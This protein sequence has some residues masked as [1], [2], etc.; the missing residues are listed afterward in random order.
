MLCCSL[1]GFLLSKPFHVALFPKRWCCWICTTDTS[2]VHW[3]ERGGCWQG[4]AGMLKLPS[5]Q[6]SWLVCAVGQ[7]QVGKR[8]TMSVDMAGERGRGS[9]EWWEMPGCAMLLVLVTPCAANPALTP[10][11]GTP[12]QN[13]WNTTQLLSPGPG[14]REE[15][16]LCFV[17]VSW[18]LFQFNLQ[19]CWFLAVPLIFVKAAPG[20]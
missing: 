5:G 10:S 2:H 13:F 9:P 12:P 6:G 7:E 20:F 11:S 16:E 8:S 14:W 4:K 18:F 19:A 3:R 17:A 1:C 15:V